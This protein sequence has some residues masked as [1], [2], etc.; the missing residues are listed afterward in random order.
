MDDGEWCGPITRP[1][2]PRKKKKEMP[3]QKPEKET[4]YY[5]EESFMNAIHPNEVNSKKYIKRSS[6]L[7]RAIIHCIE[8]N[9]GKA[10]ETQLLDY[11]TE[12]W[13]IINKYSERGVLVE[14]N[15]RVVR[16]NC[17][18]KKKGK[19]L[20]M[21]SPNDP[22]TWMFQIAA[23]RNDSP[24]IEQVEKSSPEVSSP[25]D[26][27]VI[28]QNKFEEEKEELP[29]EKCLWNCFMESHTYLTFEHIC[30]YMKKYEQNKGLFNKLPFERRIKACLISLQINHQICT[31]YQFNQSYYSLCR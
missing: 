2:T 31:T 10:T 11:I 27:P 17:A 15:I 14:P 21:Q 28:I 12:K 29:F 20:F 8:R 4:I 16:L 23:K 18:V 13:D 19:H 30:E 7:Q 9:G 22:E 25:V 3:I 26:I 1:Y 5:G 24:Q 6:P